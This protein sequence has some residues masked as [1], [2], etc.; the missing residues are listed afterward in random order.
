LTDVLLRLLVE[1]VAVALDDHA[2]R[3]APQ[4]VLVMKGAVERQ[5][6]VHPVISER[7][8]KLDAKVEVRK[9]ALS[10]S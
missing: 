7:S 5:E 4:A 1:V 9:R 10:G 2:L 8:L 6:E 3:G